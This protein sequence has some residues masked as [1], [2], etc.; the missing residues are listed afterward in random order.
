MTPVRCQCGCGE[1]AWPNQ[2]EFVDVPGMIGRATIHRRHV[3]AWISEMHRLAEIRQLMLAGRR[4][5]WPIRWRIGRTIERLRFQAAVRLHGRKQA[6][7]LALRARILYLLPL[8][9]AE[10]LDKLTPPKL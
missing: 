10:L 9:V 1:C 8:W 2:C 6:K 3:D 4:C 7:K 5:S